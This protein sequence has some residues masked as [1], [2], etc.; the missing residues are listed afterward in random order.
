M[1][2]SILTDKAPKVMIMK[3]HTDLG[4]RIDEHSENFNNVMENIRKYQI[5]YN[6]TGKYTTGF[7][8]HNG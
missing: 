2:I 4:R 6:C 5:N 8:Q 7:Q 1:E 3:M